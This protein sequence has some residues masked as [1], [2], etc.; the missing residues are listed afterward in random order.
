MLLLLLLSLLLCSYRGEASV[1]YSNSHSP[2]THDSSDGAT[3]ASA[4]AVDKSA[5]VTTDTATPT[6]L[7]A[8]AGVNKLTNDPDIAVQIVAQ[9]GDLVEAPAMHLPIGVKLAYATG[10]AGLFALAGLLGFFMPSFLLQVAQID[11][12]VVRWFGFHRPREGES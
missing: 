2:M 4:A 5:T 9:P 1:L 11:P 3:A 10:E 12:G 6:G 8:D 7:E